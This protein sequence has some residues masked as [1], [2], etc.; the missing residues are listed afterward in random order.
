ML[1]NE[2]REPEMLNLIQED[3]N[4]TLFKLIPCGQAKFGQNRPPT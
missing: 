1:R 2:S 4:A 3:E